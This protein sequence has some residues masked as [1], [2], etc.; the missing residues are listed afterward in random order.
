[1]PNTLNYRN[2]GFDIGTVSRPHLTTDGFTMIIDNSPDNHL[3]QIWTSVLTVALFAERLT[4]CPLKVDRGRVKENQIK[5]GKKITTL[6]KKR[7]FDKLFG[8]PGAKG[9]RLLLI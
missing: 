7:L 5:A 6:E 9:G 4:T 1:M 3:V 8:A 2:Q